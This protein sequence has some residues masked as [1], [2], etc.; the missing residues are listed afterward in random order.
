M[1]SKS[2]KIDATSLACIVRKVEPVMVW[3]DG[4]NGR[5]QQTDQQMRDRLTGMPVWRVQVMA[6]GVAEEDY[7]LEDVF[8]VELQG[9]DKPQVRRGQDVTFDNLKV[10]YWKSDEGRSG[11]SYRAKAVYAVEARPVGQV[12][13]GK[14]ERGGAA[15]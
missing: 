11:F 7:D 5:R 4:P 12:S 15:A 2:F 3:E 6:D 9:V 1:Y 14:A 13:E 10:R 8:T